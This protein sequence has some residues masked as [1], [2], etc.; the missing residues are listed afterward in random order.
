MGSPVRPFGPFHFFFESKQEPLPISKNSHSLVP[1]NTS[2]GFHLPRHSFQVQSHKYQSYISLNPVLG[3]GYQWG[4]P[5]GDRKRLP[6][7]K[8]DQKRSSLP[9]QAR[10]FC[11]ISID[12][13]QH[14]DVK[15]ESLLSNRPSLYSIGGVV[16]M[17]PTVLYCSP[18]KERDEALREETNSREGELGING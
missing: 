17:H 5:E 15:P 18:M 4:E 7:K 10:W 9:S 12:S 6:W 13:N 11:R 2:I 1:V 16:S 8:Y 3:H 14:G